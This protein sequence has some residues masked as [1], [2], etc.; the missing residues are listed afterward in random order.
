L[1]EPLK[2]PEKPAPQH[3]Q[4]LIDIPRQY[5]LSGINDTLQLPHHKIAKGNKIIVSSPL[6]KKKYRVK[7]VVR[8]GVSFQNDEAYIVAERQIEKK[9]LMKGLNVISREKL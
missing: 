4:V 1:A 8:T 7:N 3:Q 9:L 5:N 6:I 2:V